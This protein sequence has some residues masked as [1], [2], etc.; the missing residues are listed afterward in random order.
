MASDLIGVRMM[1]VLEG[2]SKWG[3]EDHGNPRE[4]SGIIGGKLPHEQ[5]LN[6]WSIMGLCKYVKKS[7]IGDL[8]WLIGLLAY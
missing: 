7:S 6:T 1:Q 3:A 8:V 5:F 2:F 4:Y